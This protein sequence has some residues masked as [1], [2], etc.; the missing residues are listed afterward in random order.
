MWTGSGEGEDTDPTNKTRS[1]GE[2]DR[3]ESTRIGRRRNGGGEEVE[4]EGGDIG[5]AG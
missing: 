4:R 3:G 5:A 1:V 2:G